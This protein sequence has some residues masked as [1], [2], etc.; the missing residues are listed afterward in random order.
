[1]ITLALEEDNVG[2]FAVPS[3]YYDCSPLSASVLGTKRNFFAL[4]REWVISVVTPAKNQ[5]ARISG[6]WFFQ[7]SGSGGKAL[8]LDLIFNQTGRQFFQEGRRHMPL[9]FLDQGV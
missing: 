3:C 1:L 5:K 2:P 4:E 7:C 8:R 6:L 9:L